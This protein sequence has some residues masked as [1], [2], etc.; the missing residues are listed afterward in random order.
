MVIKDA[1]ENYV[2]LNPLYPSKAYYAYTT[3]KKHWKA[4]FGLPETLVIDNGTK[5]MN[6]KYTE[7]P[8]DLK[9]FPTTYSSQ[10]IKTFGLSPNE[11]VFNQKNH[12]DL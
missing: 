10:I 3:L 4:K 2:T 12:V 6:K 7:G 11:R 1:F 8:A 5:I 9:Q